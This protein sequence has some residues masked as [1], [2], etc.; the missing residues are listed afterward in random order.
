[1][2]PRIHITAAALLAWSLVAC[3]TPEPA[4]ACM[5]PLAT[6]DGDDPLAYGV[7]WSPVS[8]HA[9]GSTTFELRLLAIE[10]DGRV[11]RVAD[12]HRS[13]V[14]HTSVAWSS[15]GTLAL[16]AGDDGRIHAFEVDLAHER[17]THVGATLVDATTVYD[18]A[19]APDQAHVLACG[20]GGELTL[21]RLHRAT[22]EL[23]IVDRVAAHERCVVARWSPSGRHAASLGRAETTAF[24]ALDPE[25][26]RL[27]PIATLESGEEPG[28]VAFGADD[29]EVVHGTFGERHRVTALRLDPA[30]GELHEQQAFDDFASGIKVIAPDPEARTWVIAAHD[31]APRLYAPDEHEPG[32]GPGPIARMPDDGSGSHGASWSP[33][34]TMLVHAASQRDRFTVIDARACP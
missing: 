17:L 9:L 23:S 25:H 8:S 11:L 4:A 33:D 30:T 12:R 28:A 24:F 22:A 20:H 15:D 26:E 10:D 31:E 27:V 3:E 34:G 6:L 21:L 5:Q 19:I 1:M 14:R 29:A 13:E 16:T 18:V 2:T 7:A 32:L